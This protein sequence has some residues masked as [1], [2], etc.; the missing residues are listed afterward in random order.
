MRLWLEQM[1]R[2]L[3]WSRDQRTTA[4]TDYSICSEQLDHTALVLATNSR[5][6]LSFYLLL[7]VISIDPLL[8][9]ACALLHLP[10]IPSGTISCTGV[11]CPGS[12]SCTGV[13]CPGKGVV[14]C[15][16]HSMRL[17]HSAVQGLQRP[18][19]CNT[20]AHRNSINHVYQLWPSSTLCPSHPFTSLSTAIVNM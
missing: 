16:P 6:A 7:N 14:W 8:A 12:I 15:T 4:H 13:C 17:A 9:V 1:T 10:L 11:C 3:S 18:S 20:H 5:Q 2:A 19:P